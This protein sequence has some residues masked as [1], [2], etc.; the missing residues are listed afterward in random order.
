MRGVC[1][2]D[3]GVTDAEFARLHQGGIRGVRFNF[4]KHLGG[5]PDMAF[6]HRV[7][8]Q[9]EPLG[10]HVV[11]HLDAQDIVKLAPVIAAIRI[12]FVIDHMARVKAKDGVEQP[13][14]RQLLD[15]MR[16]PLAWTKICGAERISST[17]APFR[18]ALP[19]IRTLA[20]AAPDRL[21]W[22]TDWPHPN[23]AGDMPNDGDL[24][25]LLA[26]ALPDE[27]LRRRVLVDNPNRLYWTG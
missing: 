11:L 8:A 3:S 26:G 27:A 6:F 1:V 9:V 19:F 24:L 15:L 4:V 16:N 5:M 13:A 7:L 18:D 17:G 22:G 2:V 20:E 14:F 10:W 12:P 25:D 23:I 21:L